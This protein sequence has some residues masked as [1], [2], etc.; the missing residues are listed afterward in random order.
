MKCFGYS[1]YSG[2]ILFSDTRHT[3]LFQNSFFQ[4]PKSWVLYLPHDGV[5]SFLSVVRQRC[6]V[7]A[8]PI[9]K[10]FF[11]RKSFFYDFSR[12]GK[13]LK[14]AKGVGGGEGKKREIGGGKQEK[15]R[16]RKEGGKKRRGEKR[17]GTGRRR[18]LTLFL[19]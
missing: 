13:K 15:G 7:Q 18:N 6:P 17:R 19:N 10:F 8:K 12:S 16:R 5:C 11:A 1:G 14:R 4:H 3:Q 2:Y 9:S